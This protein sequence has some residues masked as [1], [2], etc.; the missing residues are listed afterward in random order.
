V[1]AARP[2]TPKLLYRTK[3]KLAD[4]FILAARKH[5][6]DCK[7][8]VVSGKDIFKHVGPDSELSEKSDPEKRNYGSNNAFV[9]LTCGFACAGAGRRSC[10]CVSVPAGA[11]QSSPDTSTS[12]STE[13]YIYS[14][15]YGSL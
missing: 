10:Q 5:Y 9:G 3:T 14:L 8:Y 1:A 2:G 15:I 12:P 11:V 4:L 13:R 7:S 6:L